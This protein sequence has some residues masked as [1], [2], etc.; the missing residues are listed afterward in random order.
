MAQQPIEVDGDPDKLPSHLKP[1]HLKPCMIPRTANVKPPNLHFGWVID[2][3][4]KFMNIVREHFPECIEIRFGPEED[5]KSALSVGIA[6][7][8]C[9]PLVQG[10]STFDTCFSSTL[11]DKISKYIKVPKI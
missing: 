6:R 3:E 10:E 5:H 8:S 2:D 7:D 11:R 1:S 4:K 9:G